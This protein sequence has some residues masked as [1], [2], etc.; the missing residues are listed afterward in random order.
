MEWLVINSMHLIS[1][2]YYML[3]LQSGSLKMLAEVLSD[4]P[5]VPGDFLHP[6]CDA[7][8]L[9]NKD[10]MRRLKVIS[11]SEFSATQWRALQKRAKGGTVAKI[12]R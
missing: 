8:Y 9:I 10:Q 7:M 5:P 6:V 3:V 4:T 2:G 11:A 12:C 1:S